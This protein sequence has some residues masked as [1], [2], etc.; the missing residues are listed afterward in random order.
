MQHKLKVSKFPPKN[1]A[2]EPS[3]QQANQIARHTKPAPLI[4]QQP[5][6]GKKGWY[7]HRSVL[8]LGLL[9]S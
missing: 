8:S 7:K 6:S 5:E 2:E 4:R 1:D 9:F 3:K